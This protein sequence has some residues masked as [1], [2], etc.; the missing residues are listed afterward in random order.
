MNPLNRFFRIMLPFLISLALI[1]II[2]IMGAF[3]WIIVSPFYKAGDFFQ[4]FRLCIKNGGSYSTLITAIIVTVFF[5]NYI[6]IK[7]QAQERERQLREIGHYALIF[8]KNPNMFLPDNE[9]LVPVIS[10]DRDYTVKSQPDNS[11]RTQT[12]TQAHFLT[13]RKD[14]SCLKNIMAFAQ[15]YWKEHEKDILHGYADY[16]HKAEYPMPHF[17]H[18]CPYQAKEPEI[19]SLFNLVIDPPALGGAGIKEI[20]ITAVT[21]IGALYV[22]RVHLKI[23]ETKKDH[24][25]YSILQQTAN[26]VEKGRAKML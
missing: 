25:K 14:A 23:E 21:E 5:Q 20:W 11:P 7:N 3:L 2:F 22:C 26:Y 17:V 4:V 1:V 19:E 12:C 10:N 13:S 6:N 15:D 8:P 24:Y 16:C 18:V 9:R